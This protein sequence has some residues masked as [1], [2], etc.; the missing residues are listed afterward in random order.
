MSSRREIFLEL[1]LDASTHAGLWLDKCLPN[2]EDRGPGRQAH[3]ERLEKKITV[4][5]EYRRFFQRW[6]A[7]VAVLEPYT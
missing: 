2:V 3:F 6:K 7:S 5:N 1:E 4:S